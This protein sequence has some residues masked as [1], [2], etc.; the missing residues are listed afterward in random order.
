MHRKTK[1]ILFSAGITLLLGGCSGIST[2]HDSGNAKEIKASPS[3][4]TL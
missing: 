4:D 1:M 3:G 2:S